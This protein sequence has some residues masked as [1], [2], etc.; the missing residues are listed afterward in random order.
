MFPLGES[1]VSP[2]RTLM[3]PLG[4][5]YFLIEFQT[6]KRRAKVSSYPD[7]FIGQVNWAN[8]AAI[9]EGLFVYR[10]HCELGHYGSS[11]RWTV[12]VQDCELCQYSSGLRGS[13][14]VYK[15]VNCV[16]T[17]AACEG[18]CVCTGL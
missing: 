10:S 18:H 16:N 1:Y 11:L 5:G 12:C 9:F 2:Q 6:S 7:N 17:V 15:T 4:S 8:T 14:R 13:L 3:L